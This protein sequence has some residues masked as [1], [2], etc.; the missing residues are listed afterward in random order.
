MGIADF[1]AIEPKRAQ[2]YRHIL[3]QIVP[4]TGSKLRPWLR[5]YGRG[6]Q[7]RLSVHVADGSGLPAIRIAPPDWVPDVI[8]GDAAPVRL[9]V[10]KVKALK[11]IATVDKRGVFTRQAFKDLQL[12]PDCGCLCGWC[13]LTE[14]SLLDLTCLTFVA[15]IRS[16][17]RRYWPI[18]TNRQRRPSAFHRRQP[19]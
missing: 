13:R 16:T 17:L 2:R 14:T 4:C 9:T 8:A 11:L 3:E 5:R 18:T 10:W 19:G 15:S 7:V 1:Q 6:R 12:D